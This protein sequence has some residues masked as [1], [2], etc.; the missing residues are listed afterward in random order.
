M[1][2]IKLDSDNVSLA[3]Q[4]V[5]DT[6]NAGGIACFACNGNYRLAVNFDDQEAVM[7]LLQSKRRIARTP[8]LVFTKDVKSALRLSDMGEETMGL[9][10]KFWPGA[11]TLLVEPNHNLSKKIVKQITSKQ[12]KLGVRVPNCK[13]TQSVL[14]ATGKNLLIS[15][16]NRVKKHGETSPAQIQKNFATTVD[17]FI[18]QGDLTPGPKSTIVDTAGG[19]LT[20]VRE[21]E[22]SQGEIFQ[23]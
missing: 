20:I 9:V 18:H 22:V 1:E 5:V 3:V 19:K 13:F 15:S 14:K 10:Q 23:T 12:G 8:G 7:A 11:L 17:V 21:G 16:A 4:K 2:S 6:I